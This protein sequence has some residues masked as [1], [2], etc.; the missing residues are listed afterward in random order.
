[1]KTRVVLTLC[2]V[3][4]VGVV[5]TA[6]AQLIAGSPEDRAF[7]KID[8]ENNVDAKAALLLE[9]EK[10][11]PQSKV[12]RDVYLMLMQIYQEKNDTAK[13]IEFGEKTIR[14][15]AD[16]LTALMTVCR[17]YSLERR[18]LDR[19]VQYAERA[20]SV[21]GKMKSQ[22]AVP[23]YSEEQWKQ[24]VESNEQLAKTYLAYAKSLKP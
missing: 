3:F 10:E 21:A 15:D 16:N 20:V 24:Y 13:I 1:M 14:V 18:N 12:L 22:P 7:Q 2:V 17:T 5:S 23:G 8:A 6:H 9:F 11:F 4:V 19:A